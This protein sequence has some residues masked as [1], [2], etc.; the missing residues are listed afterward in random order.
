MTQRPRIASTHQTT[1]HQHDSNRQQPTGQRD[2]ARGYDPEG[3]DRAQ[4]TSNW[5]TKGYG[6][7]SEPNGANGYSLML[8]EYYTI[9]C[10]LLTLDIK[11]I[12]MYV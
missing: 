6:V 7:A 11:K 10:A 5:G 3:L 8:Q 12:K 1:R 9:G 2:R 4:A